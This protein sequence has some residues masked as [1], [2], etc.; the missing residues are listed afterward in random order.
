MFNRVKAE[1]PVRVAVIG[2]GVFGGFHAAKYA[3]NPDVELIAVVDVDRAKAEAIAAR[4]DV[5]AS[6]DLDAI[7]GQVDAVSI[8]APAG[9]H[10]R[11]ARQALEAGV[12][13]LVEKPLA[14]RSDHAADLVRLARA[15]GL[16]LQVGHQERYVFSQFGVLSRDEKPV[17]VECRRAGPFSGRCMDVSVVMDLMIHDLDLVHQ[18]LPGAIRS[19]TADA[20]FVHGDLAD[21]V[22]ADLSFE[23]GAEVRLF[24]S[25]NADEKQRSMRLVY[26][27]GEI[28]IDFVN[29][30][31]T[32]TTSAKLEP[33]FGGEDVDGKPSI[34]SDPLGYGIAH[35]VQCVHAGDDPIVTGEEARRAVETALLIEDA[36]GSVA[37]EREAMIA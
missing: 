22:T 27:D 10:Y 5:A 33:A 34:A 36:H 8:T 4:H 26:L 24:A 28:F 32:N 2:A 3:G 7:L 11:I 30:T 18:V 19:T 29:R 20:E 35:F 9:T 17:Y 6:T 31:L 15:K 16:V 14:L 37:A 13:C 25:R 12:H 1:R 23:S 21:E